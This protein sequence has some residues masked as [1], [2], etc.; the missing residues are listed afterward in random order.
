VTDKQTLI[1]FGFKNNP[2]V[3]YT[4][5]AEYDN[6]CPKYWLGEDAIHTIL[7]RSPP[8]NALKLAGAVLTPPRQR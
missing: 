1:R 2:K 8:N 6:E 4:S 5:G 7:E 3:S